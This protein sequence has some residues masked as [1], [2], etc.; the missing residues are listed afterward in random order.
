[1][2]YTALIEP[3]VWLMK[4]LLSKEDVIIH[5]FCYSFM[6]GRRCVFPS[7]VG[8]VLPLQLLPPLLIESDIKLQFSFSSLVG[9]GH[10]LQI[11]WKF[12]SEIYF[13]N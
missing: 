10:Q 8:C 4:L 5:F 11:I 13:D 9:F 1:M 3:K 7:V 6:S 2:T 12:A